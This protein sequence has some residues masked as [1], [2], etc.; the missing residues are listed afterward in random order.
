MSL[1]ARLGNFPAASARAWLSW[2]SSGSREQAEANVSAHWWE[3]KYPFP[4]FP[5][6]AHTM[7][8]LSLLRDASS[9]I[10]YSFCQL[11]K[12][13]RKTKMTLSGVQMVQCSVTLCVCSTGVI[14]TL[15]P[16][17]PPEDWMLF[18]QARGG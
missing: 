13:S 5:K 1:L 18:F 8:S 6:E 12:T 15:F 2:E 4:A 9:L 3:N 16:F 11:E 10:S 17:A 7:Q 14:K